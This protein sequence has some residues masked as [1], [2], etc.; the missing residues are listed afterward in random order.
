[1]PQSALALKE[2]VI[3]MSVGLTELTEK[4]RRRLCRRRSREVM[5]RSIGAGAVVV[6][7]C[8]LGGAAGARNLGSPAITG[9]SPA[10]AQPGMVVTITGTSLTGATVSFHKARSAVPPVTATQAETI[11]NPDGT[12]ILLTIPDGSDAANGMTAPFGGDRLVVTT[13]GGSATTSFMVLPLARTGHAPVIT[14]ITPRR[15]IPGHTVRISGSNLNGGIGVW[16]TG[17]KAKFRV[18]SSSTILARVPRNARSGR[19]S[20][21]TAVGMTASA[22][23]FT[24]LTPAT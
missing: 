6:L 12:R 2:G 3:D 5:I 21:K 4:R 10:S 8:A 1:M 18:P 20:V 17:T 15:A 19:W 13:P 11:V 22:M 9:V 24:V 16:L 23:R 7:A 14:A